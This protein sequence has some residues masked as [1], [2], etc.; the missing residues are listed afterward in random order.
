M[1][2][3]RDRCHLCSISYHCCLLTNLQLQERHS[4]PKHKQEKASKEAKVKK[5][6]KF[7]FKS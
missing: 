5:V 1:Q 2:Q 7:K 3:I 4:K 6:S